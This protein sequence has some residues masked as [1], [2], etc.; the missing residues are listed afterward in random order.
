MP[1]GLSGKIGGS[2]AFGQTQKYFDRKYH[3]YAGS[4]KSEEYRY[5]AEYGRARMSTENLSETTQRD[6]DL[7]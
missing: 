6:S 2:E 4:E 1:R 3:V 7:I 5:N